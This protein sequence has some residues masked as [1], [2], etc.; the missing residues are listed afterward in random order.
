MKHKKEK[1]DKAKKKAASER[2]GQR[3]ADAAPTLD[4]AALQSAYRWEKLSPAE[5]EQLQDLASCKFPRSSF[6]IQ[7]AAECGAPFFRRRRRASS[8]PPR[9]PRGTMTRAGAEG[10]R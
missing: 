6:Q 9:R 1:K 8:R 2:A 10:T 7:D 4:Q 3:D 5:F